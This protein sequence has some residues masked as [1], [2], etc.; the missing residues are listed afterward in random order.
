M[1]GNC[2]EEQAAHKTAVSPEPAVA[3]LP[4]AL[5]VKSLLEDLSF[6]EWV[7]STQF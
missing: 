3:D 2:I 1:E 4:L 5:P 7:Y 6:M